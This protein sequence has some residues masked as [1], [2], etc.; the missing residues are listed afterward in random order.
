MSETPGKRLNPRALSFWDL[1]LY[2]VAMT[3]SVRWIATAAAAGPAALPLWSA[4]MLGFMGPLVI[5]TAELTTRFP[6][7]GGVYVWTRD[8]LGP[9]SGFICGWLY[10]TCNLPFF[11]SVLYFIVN[12]IGLTG[13][14]LTAP[15]L[16]SPV[17]FASIALAIALAVA[18]LSLLGLGAGKWV[19]NFGGFAACSIAL[20]M[21][22][23]GG[24]LAWRHG[25]ATDFVHADYRPPLTA[26]G[27]VLWATMVFAFGG[28]EAMAFLK[29]DVKGGTRQILKVLA[30]VGVLLVFAYSLATAG[31]LSI[32]TPGE[33]SHLSGLPDA[34]KACLDRLGLPYLTPVALGITA[35]ALLGG[36][37]S[38]F[39]VAARLP[40]VV[41]AL[42][43][44][45]LAGESLK[46]AYDFLVSMTV[47]SYTLPFAF[48]FVVYW[49]VQNE[50]L[51]AAGWDPPGGPSTARKIALVGLVVT[52]SAIVCTLI[53]SGDAKDKL[54]E[55]LKLVLSSGILILIGAGAY[56]LSHFRKKRPRECP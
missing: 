12:L 8:V 5:A 7:D 29:D 43:I 31:M 20:L 11:S 18:G 14:S 52:I 54:A 28:P 25:P 42:V 47:L 1:T 3:L 30:T 49:K 36:Y 34:I 44:L 23:G 16:A 15:I 35:L 38:W 56:A 21:V 45:S 27:A 22:V 24:V 19:S 39:G 33:I 55:T 2:A 37:M 32:L 40:F 10:W 13:G 41:A 26:D 46:A 6:G 9:F 48:L 17:L 4:A 53:P 50:T 51:P